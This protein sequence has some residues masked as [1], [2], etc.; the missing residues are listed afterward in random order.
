MLKIA[1][2]QDISRTYGAKIVPLITKL[3]KCGDVIMS[4]NND[5]VVIDFIANESKLDEARVIMDDIS[6]WSDALW[7]EVGETS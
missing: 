1:I 3:E 2:K 7:A 4:A 6:N 5:T